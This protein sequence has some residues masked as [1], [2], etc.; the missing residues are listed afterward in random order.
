LTAVKNV[1]A[2]RF[3]V[4]V[5]SAGA[6][7][8]VTGATAY[9]TGKTALNQWVRIAG[10]E[11]AQRSGTQV[12]AIG[13][14]NVDTPMQAVIREASVRDFPNQPFFVEMYRQ[15]LL[16]SPDEVARVIWAKVHTDIPTGT[17]LDDVGAHP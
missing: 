10:A 5:T 7:A 1:T 6:G 9:G 2:R 13:P 4:L 15:R 12:L 8:V 17:V 16:R 14:G 11:Q 3:L